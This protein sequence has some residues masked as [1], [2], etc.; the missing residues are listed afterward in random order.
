MYKQIM[1][2]TNTLKYM[3]YVFNNNLQKRYLSP[4][5]EIRVLINL[6]ASESAIKHLIQTI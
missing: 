3:N 1:Y 5:K 4:I 2:I 6:T